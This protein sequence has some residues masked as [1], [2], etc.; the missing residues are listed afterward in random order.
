MDFEKNDMSVAPTLNGKRPKRKSVAKTTKTKEEIEKE[1][2]LLKEKEKQ[3]KKDQ[4]KYRQIKEDAIK[5]RTAEKKALAAK[6]LAEEKKEKEKAKKTKAKEKAK[7]KAE[8][9]ALAKKA[10]EKEKKAKIKEKMEAEALAKK[11]KEKEKK[12][13]QR[14]ELRL[15]NKEKEKAKR[16]RAK[17]RAKARYIRMLQET[18]PDSLPDKLNTRYICFKIDGY[19]IDKDDAGNV[20]RTEYNPNQTWYETY[21]QAINAIAR[22]IL[23]MLYNAYPDIYSQYEE[24]SSLA[25]VQYYS[26]LQIIN[27]AFANNLLTMNGKSFAS[28]KDAWSTN[29]PTHVT[30]EVTGQPYCCDCSISKVIDHKVYFHRCTGCLFKERRPGVNW[31]TEYDEVCKKV[32]N[33]AIRKHNA[34]L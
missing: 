5:R 3:K 2:A 14:E 30:V 16:K 6:K 8:A 4:K 23:K 20:V 34:F 18:N 27:E 26:S 21:N 13:K 1:K 12:A 29:F 11:A 25:K 15:H 19:S 10:K 22:K 7:A 31:C 9:E 28:A 33:C 24:A 32:K 17:A